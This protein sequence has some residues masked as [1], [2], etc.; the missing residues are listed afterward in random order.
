M[1]LSEAVRNVYGV[2]EMY[3]LYRDADSVTTAD[4]YAE[5]AGGVLDWQW[6]VEC[7]NCILGSTGDVPQSY[8]L[9]RLAKSVMRYFKVTGDGCGIEKAMYLSDVL[10]AGAVRDVNSRWR[11][12]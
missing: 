9:L 11:T 6:K 1:G 7:P 2:S 4:C 10:R 8:W 3:M 12:Q 5:P